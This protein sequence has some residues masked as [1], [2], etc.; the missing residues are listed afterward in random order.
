MLWSNLLHYVRTFLLPVC[1]IFLHTFFSWLPSMGLCLVLKCIYLWRNAFHQIKRIR[2]ITT[3]K[4]YPSHFKLSLEV[5]RG[6]TQ[7]N[8]RTSQSRLSLRR[9]R[10]RVSKRMWKCPCTVGCYYGHNV[11]CRKYRFSVYRHLFEQ[12]Y[13][14]VNVIF[15]IW[16]LLSAF[17]WDWCESLVV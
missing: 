9:W 12:N 17:Q 8:L 16:F 5:Y 13:C 6:M 1:S 2:S 11:P 15:V 4:K 10:V 7:T 14:P 3:Q